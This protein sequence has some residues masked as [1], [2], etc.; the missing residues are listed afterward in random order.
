[1]AGL[2]NLKWLN[3]GGY[4]KPIKDVTPLAKLTNLESLSIGV[5]PGGNK[6][7]SIPDDQKAML[8]EALPNCEIRF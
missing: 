7:L 5:G 2:T 4:Y 3:L 8:K 1:L 6:T